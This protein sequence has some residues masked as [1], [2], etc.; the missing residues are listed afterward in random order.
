MSLRLVVLMCLLPLSLS[1]RTV[2]DDELALIWH[3]VLLF[4]KDG[5]GY[6]IGLVLSWYTF[7]DEAWEDFTPPWL[8]RPLARWLIN[9]EDTTK[10]ELG[11]HTLGQ[12]MVTPEDV[13]KLER[14]PGDAPYA[15]LLY[16]R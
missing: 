7:A 15:G 8:T 4:D 10:F 3:N 11:V 6:T 1:V 14:E 13:S 9:S 5:G 2:D 12:M 16:W